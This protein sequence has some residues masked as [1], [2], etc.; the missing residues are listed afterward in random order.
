MGVVTGG[1]KLG[2]FVI[3]GVKIGGIVTAGTVIFRS[4]I[5]GLTAFVRNSARDFATT[6]GN[7]NA[8]IG[9]GDEIWLING[10]TGLMEAYTVT[11][12]TITRNAARDV[13]LG[14]GNWE[15]AAT[16]E[17]TIFV[18]DDSTDSVLGLDAATLVPNGRDVNLDSGS[19]DGALCSPATNSIWF[20]NDSFDQ[21]I[22]Y[23]LDN[24]TRNAARDISIP[25]AQL[26][27]GT[28]I[29]E[30]LIL[31]DDSSNSLIAYDETTLERQTERD[32]SLESGF[33]DSVVSRGNEIWVSHREVAMME[34][35]RLE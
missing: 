19:W 5:A 8:G 17:T 2:G 23:R 15:G 28:V 20:L 27:G 7:V 12:T 11:D 14:T 3:G 21:A 35:Y 13:D 16:D 32:V 10:V 29:D 4:E 31:I 6:S 22:C 30:S 26:D 34:S 25:F 9:V 18:V 1:N 24:L 33:W